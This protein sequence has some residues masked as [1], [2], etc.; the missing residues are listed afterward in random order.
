MMF[1][2]EVSTEWYE[3]YQQLVDS[4]DD[5]SDIVFEDEDE[6]EES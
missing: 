6:D 5:L 3:Q 2:Y 4:V 1:L